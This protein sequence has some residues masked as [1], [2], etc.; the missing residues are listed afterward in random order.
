MSASPAEIVITCVRGAGARRLSVLTP[1]HRHDPTPLLARLKASHADVE[2]ILIDDGSGDAALLARVTEAAG[3]LGFPAKI[4]V[5]SGNRGRAAARNRLIAEAQGEYLLFLDADMIPDADNFLDRWLDVIRRQRPFVAFGGLSLRHTVRSRATDLHHSIFARSDC[6]GAAARSKRA[7][8]AVA[9]SNLLVR[10]DLM[11]DLPFDDSFTGWGFED[12]DWALSAARRAPITHT[13]NPATHAG[14]DSVDALLRKGAEAG[15]NFARLARK[16]P[17]EARRFFAHRAARVL[18]HIPGRAAVRAFCA[19][20]A[21]DP[22][23][24]APM[25]VRHAAFKVF[26]AAHYAEHLP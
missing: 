14:L 10:R 1:F 5:W 8:Q 7:A 22:F 13:D 18:K 12:V 4:I 25:P 15:P 24:A 16:H 21:R 26:R 6:H 17:G 11:L 9:S 2:L 23:G 19:W 3:R 20:L